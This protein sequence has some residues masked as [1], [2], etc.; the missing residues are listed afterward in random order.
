MSSTSRLTFVV[1]APDMSDSEAL[2]R[3]LAVRAQHL[4]GAHRNFEAGITSTFSVAQ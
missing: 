4:A 2:Q 3:R 1:W